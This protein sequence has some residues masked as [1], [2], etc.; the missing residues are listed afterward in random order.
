[1]ELVVY[2]G[3]TKKRN[4]TKI[5]DAQGTTYD[6]KLKDGCSILAPSFLISGVD[7]SANY[8]KFN[9]RYYYID[10]I[11]LSN[12]T[13]Y[14]IQC[15]V[16]VLATYKTQINSSSAYVN[17]ST[18]QFDTNIA[19]SRYPFK[20]SV[21]I[22]EEVPNTNLPISD[23]SGG[24]YVV[25]YSGLKVADTENPSN[26]YMVFSGSANFIGFLNY[27]S[28]LCNGFLSISTNWGQYINEVKWYPDAPPLGDSFN[29]IGIMGFSS[30]STPT[31]SFTGNLLAS[32]TQGKNAIIISAPDHPQKLRG[33]WLNGSA[34]SEIFITHPLF[35]N[36]PIDC[37]IAKEKGN[38]YLSTVVDYTTGTASLYL[39]YGQASKPAHRCYTVNYG[40]PVQARGVSNQFNFGRG[41]QLAGSIVGSLQTASTGNFIGSVNGIM[42]AGQGLNA[43]P[44]TVG[45]N[46]T[47][48][49]YNRGASVIHRYK[50]LVDEHFDDNGRPLCKEVTL[51]TLTG[52]VECDIHPAFGCTPQE[53]DEIVNYM[54]H[55]VYLE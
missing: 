31:V 33:D 22:S 3:F 17:R 2:S 52:Y 15:S 43:E 8:C 54:Q 38:A 25:N 42:N 37:N 51:N 48:T 16:D 36:I 4:S 24:Y 30:A 49:L 26:A 1:M 53:T 47:R 9:N 46:G 7:L 10:N 41:L 21:D 34:G 23:G 19:D 32:A 5:P 44:V 50:L 6:V 29:K 40:V 55:G 45:G 39:E 35:G 27:L 14:E 13:I 11:I 12:S 18:S 20:S 28:A